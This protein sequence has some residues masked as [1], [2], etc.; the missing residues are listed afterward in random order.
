MQEFF[1]F[2]GYV[3]TTVSELVIARPVENLKMNNLYG[4]VF[5]AQNG[6]ICILT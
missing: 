6:E 2:C 4:G 1:W 5:F 3:N